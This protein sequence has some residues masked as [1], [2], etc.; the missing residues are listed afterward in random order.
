MPHP[1]LPSGIPWLVL[2]FWVYLIIRASAKACGLL[3]RFLSSM[4]TRQRAVSHYLTVCSSP[5]CTCS[6]CGGNGDAQV[7]DR[8]QGVGLAGRLPVG[9]D[10]GNNLGKRMETFL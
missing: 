9:L 3:G 2:V 5:R 7:T 10:Y 6:D 1:C 4:L 8:S